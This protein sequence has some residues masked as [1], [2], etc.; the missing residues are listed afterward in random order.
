[1][2]VLIRIAVVTGLM[3]LFTGVIAAEEAEVEAAVKLEGGLGT[4]DWVVIAFYACMM[5]AVGAYYARKVETADDYYLGGRRMRPSMVGLSLFATLISTIS[6]L[7]VPG[8]VMGHGPTASL[9]YLASLPIIYVVVGY[10][11]IP[12]IT[13]LPITSAYELL[14]TRLGMPARLLGSGIFLLIRFIWMGLVVYTASRAV[15]TAMGLSEAV[16]MPAIITVGTITVIYSSMGGLR[17][18]VLTDAIQCLLL[19]G[20]AIICVV[21]ITVKMGGFGWLPTQWSETWDTQPLFSF[22]PTVRVTVVGSLIATT[23][24]WVCTAGSDQMAIQRY[25][26]TRDAKSARRAFLVNN[27]ADVC[28]NLTLV[29]LGFAL[30]GFFRAHYP[31]VMDSVGVDKK[32]DYLFPLFVVN[33]M[34]FGMAGL[35]M[36]GMLA[37]AMSSL[38]SG[39]NSASTVVNND[40]MP[41][42]LRRKLDEKTKVRYAKWVSVIIGVIIICLALVVGNIRGNLFEVT[43]KTSNLL[44]APLFSLFFLALFVKRA[45]TFS[46]MYAGAYGF[47]VAVVVA[48][49]ELTGA[50]PISFQWIGITALLASVGT[51]VALSRLPW[52]RMGRNGRRNACLA[53]AFPLLVIMAAFLYAVFSAP[54]TAG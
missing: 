30:L 7:A 10:L 29:S 4:L 1:M 50:T 19:F 40:F 35:V 28:V 25:L 42:F 46:A 41:L 13:K 14:E 45:N 3:C 11:L 22:D 36:A 17:A 5:L 23:T 21:I 53:A 38:S 31:A 47:V 52:E 48:F 51:G 24:W 44:V 15:T 37:A 54:P 6:Y 39:V 20:A 32:V 2:P 16:L 27:L 49:W 18:V 43:Q 12:H 26:S 9:M 8:E 33:Y 34:K